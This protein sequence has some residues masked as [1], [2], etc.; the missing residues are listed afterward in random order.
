[1]PKRNPIPAPSLW[2][3]LFAAAILVGAATDWASLPKPDNAAAYLGAVR[4]AAGR[5]P[6]RI[7]DWVGQD[8]P[9]PQA[10]VAML[11]PN[12]I[13]SRRY[14]DSATGLAVDV[15]LVH[16]G[17]ARDIEAH[18]PPVCMVNAG[19]TMCA[20]DPHDWMIDAVRLTGTE[21]QFVRRAFDRPGAVA[22][23][24]VILLPGGRVVRDMDAVA[25]AA[26]DVSRR[27]YGAGQIQVVT[28]AE[29]P[30]DRRQA[31]VIELVGAMQGTVKAIL[32]GDAR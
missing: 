31:V 11:H 5:I 22:V 20:A 9:V 16:C 15:L 25:Q 12:V 4:E 10:A 32:A 14:V 6:M 13:L 1:M 2:P 26:G 8:V 7:D 21:Y 19:W 3:A 18:Y 30:P 23:S 17:D 29:L 28:P 24:N 27:Y